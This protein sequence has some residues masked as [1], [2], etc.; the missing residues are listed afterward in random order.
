[1]FR[2]ERV[3]NLLYQA[4]L[5]AGVVGLGWYLVS[6]TLH[7][8]EARQIQSGFAFLAREAG[9]EIAEKRIAFEPSDSYARALAVGLA[10][11][12]TVA[13]IGI[14][15]ATLIGTLVG[16]ARLSTNWLLARLAS[17]Y[18]EVMRNIPLLLPILRTRPRSS[19]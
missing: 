3:R 6:N 1:M 2:S 12:L 18:V 10:N 15:V 9:F 17:G 19:E 7:N 13:A 8:L 16:I 11:T 14:V 4:L 5:L